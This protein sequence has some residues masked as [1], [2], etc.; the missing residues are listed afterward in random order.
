MGA[1]GFV[2]PGLRDR[3]GDRLGEE[4]ENLEV[5]LVELTVRRTH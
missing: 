2:Q 4:A 1:L 5:V 3:G